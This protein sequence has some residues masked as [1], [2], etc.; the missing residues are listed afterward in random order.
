MGRFYF[1]FRNTAFLGALLIG[2]QAN[3][4]GN[5]VTPD[6][7]KVSIECTRSSSLVLINITN[8]RRIGPVS[9]AIRDS[10]GRSLYY[11]EGKA[12]TDELVRRLDKGLFPPGEVTLTVQSRDVSE[13]QAFLV[14]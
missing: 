7:S 2:F 6:S 4:G 8:H 3:A 13:T 14:Q 9:I 10:N 12:M 5:E 11:E 1:I